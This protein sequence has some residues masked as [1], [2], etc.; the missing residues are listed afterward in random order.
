M[1][2]KYIA[3]RSCKRK[4]F[5][6][7]PFCR[8]N[9]VWNP[10]CQGCKDK[11]FKQYKKL[12]ANKPLKKVTKKQAK[13]EKN[14]FSVFTND[15]TKSVESKLPKD[16]LHECIDGCNRHNSIKWGL[17]IPLTREEHQDPAILLKWLFKAQEWFIKE[18]G[19]DKFM[20][21]FKI[22]YIEKHKKIAKN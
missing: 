19:Y 10:T 20:E 8:N 12:E 17:V 4:G 16:D 1:K 2:C 14:R 9:D 3:Y 6:N 13:A 21:V 15:L 5:K 7:T 11:D 22:D 18:H